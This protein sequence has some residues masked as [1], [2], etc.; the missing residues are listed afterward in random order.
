LVGFVLFLS[1]VVLVMHYPQ[2]VPFVFAFH[3]RNINL[4]YIYSNNIQQTLIHGCCNN[5][6]ALIRLFGSLSSINIKASR[7]SIDTLGNKPKSIVLLITFEI[8]S[9]SLSLKYLRKKNK[10]MI[11][12]SSCYLPIKWCHTTE[13]SKCNNTN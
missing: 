11:F 5:S 4:K 12:F 1:Y 7:Q 6:A 10:I 8:I 2:Q 13:K 3:A 9:S